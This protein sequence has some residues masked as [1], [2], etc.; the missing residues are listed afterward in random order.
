M[1]IG[2]KHNHGVRY[3]QIAEVLAS[4]GL[5][6]F[7]SLLDLE[8]WVPFGRG[9]HEHARRRGAASQPEQVRAAIEAL[10]AT[11]IKLG[12]IASTRADLL[13]PDYQAELAKLQD[14]APTV[15]STI[16]RD[17]VAQEL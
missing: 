6:Y 4:L 15:A 9:R 14:E 1:A 13:P 12:Q 16:I 11:F 17:T 10:G 5:R 2:V 7:L 3:R 8:R